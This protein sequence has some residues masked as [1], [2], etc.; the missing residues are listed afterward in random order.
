MTK[1]RHFTV[2]F[3]IFVLGMLGSGGCIFK[4]TPVIINN[5]MKMNSHRNPL[6]FIERFYLNTYFNLTLPKNKKAVCYRPVET[7]IQYGFDTT[8]EHE[9]VTLDDVT[10]AIGN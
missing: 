10:K 1:N 2:I 8:P 7:K 9:E 5:F 3:A 6:K 4:N